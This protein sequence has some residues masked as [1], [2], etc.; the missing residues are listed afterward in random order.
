MKL[1]MDEAG[2]VVV[3]DGKPVYVTDDGKEVAFDAPGTVATISRLNGEAKGHRERAE[4]AEKALKSYEGID[5]PK[6]ALKALQTVRNID[7]KKLIDAGETERVRQEAIKAVEERFKPVVEERDTLMRQLHDEKIG[8]AFARSRFIADKIA[9]PAD[10]IQAAFGSRFT[11]ENGKI[12]ARDQSGNQVYSKANPGEPASFEEAL[13]FLV[14]AYPHKAALL[15]SSGASGSG[16][17]SSNGQGPT[18]PKVMTRAQFEQIPQDQR[19]FKIREG[20]QI[21]DG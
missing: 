4:A 18:G 3:S 1:K 17:R 16:A 9:V 21:V 8:G 5:D 6:A 13:E 2:H 12:I 14:D 11:L 7:D 19:M 20:Y 15:K 10:I